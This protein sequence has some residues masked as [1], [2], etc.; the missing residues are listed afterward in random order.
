ME[1][2]A[3]KQGATEDVA[4]VG[5]LGEEAL[6]VGAQPCHRKYIYIDDTIIKD[7]CQDIFATKC[8]EIC[9]ALQPA[10]QPLFGNEGVIP[11]FL[12]QKLA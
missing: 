10:R 11:S 8:L 9:S 3:M 2:L 4:E 12:R 7:S 5:D 1:G 6:E